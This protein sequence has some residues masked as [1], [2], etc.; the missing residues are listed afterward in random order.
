MDRPTKVL[1]LIKGLGAGG[2]EKLLAL[3]LPH[4]DRD[5]FEYEVGY[6]LP[7]KE[8]LVP[9]F[10]RAGV[11]VFC[12]NLH[13]A[14]DLRIIPRLA[15][16]LR[17]RRVDVLHLHLPYAG[18]V[19]RVASRL[20][21]VKAVVY[22]EHNLWERY[23]WLTAAVN[24]MT[25]KWNDTV[26]SVS[27]EVERSIRTHYRQNG[28]L[29]LCTIHNG[30]DCEQLA[31]IPQ[32]PSGVRREFGIP[33]DHRLVVH[34]ANFLPKKRHVDLLKAAQSMLRQDPF[35]TFLLVG[36]GPLQ[37]DIKAHARSLGI[38]SN[39]IFTGFRDDVPELLAASDSFVLSSLYEGLPVSLLESMAVGTPVVA[40]RV[41]GIPEV[42]T[43]AVEGFLVEPLHPEQLSEK[44]LALLHSSGLQHRFSANAK[45]RVRKQF[46]VRRMVESTEALY[47]QMLGEKEVP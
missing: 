14:Y 19:G 40:T 3:S 16:L 46:D 31:G 17:E 13:K 30:V 29:K 4:L 10:R 41:G 23:H 45:E 25:F 2:A 43:D 11:P 6:L 38:D 20:S 9:E 39:V 7:W 44:L 36:Q 26:I 33:L 22:T 1:T 37:E 21:P 28:N 34:V 18:I 32:N 35:I 8:A 12:L 42:I 27:R 15:R 24:R 5:R 47:A